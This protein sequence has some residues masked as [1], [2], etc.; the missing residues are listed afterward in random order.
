MKPDYFKKNFSNRIVRMMALVLCLSFCTACAGTD[1]DVNQIAGNKGEQDFNYAV[2]VSTPSV[3]VNQLGYHTDSVKT[4]VFVGENVPDKFS[5]VDKETG[6]S[7]FEGEIE[8]K[9]YDKDLKTDVSI[10]TFTE[11]TKEGEYYIVCDTIGQS[12]HFSIS[13]IIYDDLFKDLQKE[14]YDNRFSAYNSQTEQIYKFDEKNTVEISGGWY[15][16]YCKEKKERDVKAGC[17]TLVNL[18]MGIELYPGEHTDAVGISES[19]NEIP[20]I[21]DEAAYEALWLLK[22]QDKKSGAVYS[23][24]SEEGGEVVLGET[25]MEACQYFIIGMAKISY[26]MKNYDNAFATEC[27][28]ASDA[29]WKYV[30]SIRNSR[31]EEQ[32]D[33]KAEIDESLRFFGAAELFRAS[34]AYRYHTVVKEYVPNTTDETKWSKEEYLGIYTY[35]GTRWYVSKTICEEWMKQIMDMG[36]NVAI[37]SKNSPMLAIPVEA[38]AGCQ[39]LLWKMTVMTSIDY[40][41][42]NHEYDTILENN[43]HYLLGRNKE[44]VSYIEGYGNDQ[45]MKEANLSLTDDLT[46]VSEIVFILSEILSNQ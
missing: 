28:R 18:L 5:V 39:N 22:M 37:E 46:Q 6:E 19:G 41:I 8:R 14:I 11:L 25:T 36:E 32:A 31:A 2:P 12:Y 24:V 38:G 43:L 23:G 26:S 7:V 20:D 45:P 9:G 21:L 4:A 44:A 42:G 27:L 40:I 35:L 10:G 13:G 30:E 16:T 33:L 3:L 1:I 17:E 15:T 34:G 29:A